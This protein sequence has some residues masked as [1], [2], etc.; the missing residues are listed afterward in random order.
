MNEYDRLFVSHPSPSKNEQRTDR[1]TH[2]DVQGDTVEADA[3]VSLGERQGCFLEDAERLAFA[4]NKQ[5]RNKQEKKQ[6]NKK[7]NQ[8][9]NKHL[10]EEN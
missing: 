4:R 5:K 1:A 3:T 6:A 10:K 8:Q 7:T 2:A 9:T